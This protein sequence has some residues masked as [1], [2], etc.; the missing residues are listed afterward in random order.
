MSSMIDTS[1]SDNAAGVKHRGEGKTAKLDVRKDDGLE[2]LANGIGAEEFARAEVTAAGVVDHDVEMAG[3][4]ER[5]V[6]ASA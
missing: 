2:L 3:V 6:E 5:S 1:P 4:L